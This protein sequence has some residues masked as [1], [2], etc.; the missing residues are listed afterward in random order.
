[1]WGLIIDFNSIKVISI[2]GKLFVAFACAAVEEC[3]FE[4]IFNAPL[5]NSYTKPI[6]IIPTNPNVTIKP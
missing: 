2:T 4:G 3:C 1:M 5:P 6:V